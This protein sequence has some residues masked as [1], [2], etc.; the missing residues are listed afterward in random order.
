[1][2]ARLY[3]RDTAPRAPPAASTATASIDSH[4][5]RATGS[6]E[7]C[8]KEGHTSMSNVASEAV[9][10]F[11]V[12]VRAR[13]RSLSCT[14]EASARLHAPPCVEEMN[15]YRMT[16]HS[17]REK[18]AAAVMRVAR[19][20]ATI[21]HLE[22]RR[23]HRSRSGHRT[24]QDAAVS[25]TIMTHL[26]ARIAHLETTNAMLR[27]ALDDAQATTDALATRTSSTPPHDYQWY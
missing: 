20:D 2:A 13:G 24:Q 26:L 23:R 12:P 25:N 16:V 15:A 18:L 5:R 6:N 14:A 10:G 9:V 3:I 21:R 27:S 8:T 22:K 17:L 4:A 1:M 19:R 11:L 7:T